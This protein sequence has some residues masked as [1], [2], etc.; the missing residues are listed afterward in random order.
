MNLKRMIPSKRRQTENCA[1]LNLF[2]L[3]F[4][5]CKVV[6][7]D[8]KIRGCLTV[9]GWVSEKGYTGKQSKC[10]EVGKMD[11]FIIL[12]VVALSQMHTYVKNDQIWAY[13]CLFYL[14]QLKVHG[15]YY[16]FKYRKQTEVSLTNSLLLMLTLQRRVANINISLKTVPN[17]KQGETAAPHITSSSFDS[18]SKAVAVN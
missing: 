3:N 17:G 10:A 13:Y 16:I 6:H 4:R 12:T 15:I 7:N 8:R 11:T 9:R 1:W 2:V 5:K 18:L 14:N